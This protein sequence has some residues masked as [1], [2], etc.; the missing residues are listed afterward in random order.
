MFVTH[1]PTNDPGGTVGSI[2]SESIFSL[3]SLKLHHLHRRL[4]LQ[5]IPTFPIHKLTK[6]PE[7][8]PSIPSYNSIPVSIP[9]ETH[10]FPA[11]QHLS[12]PFPIISTTTENT[13][14]QKPVSR[15]SWQKSRRYPSSILSESLAQPTH[16]K[17]P[18]P[19]IHPLHHPNKSAYP[20]PHALTIHDNKP[21]SKNRKA[22][23]HDRTINCRALS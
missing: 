14:P 7:H 6:T 9:A 5:R 21:V 16:P 2:K 3:S 4:H 19:R 22:H 8:N 23:H 17:S 18:F 10:T 11:Y 1:R 20:H 12:S 15:K 13:M